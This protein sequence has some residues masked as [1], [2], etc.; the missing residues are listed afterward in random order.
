[1]KLYYFRHPD[2]SKNF[3][4]ELN[5]W[6]WDQ[7]IPGILDE[8]ENS[9]FIGIGT[10]LNERLQSEVAN[11][12]RKFVFGSGVGYGSGI[13]HIDDSWTIYCLRGPLSARALGVAPELALTDAG[14]LIRRCF[15]DTTGKLYKFSYMPHA[16]Y[17][18]TAWKTVTEQLGFG[19]ID[20]HLP[21][22]QV[23]SS[24]SQTEILLTEALHGAI[25]ANALRVPWIPL[26]SGPSIL[27]FKWRDWCS[28]VGLEYKPRTIT[29]LWDPPRRAQVLSSLRGWIKKKLAAI[30]LAH[31]AKTERPNLSNEELIERLTGELERRLQQFKD[32]VVT[33]RL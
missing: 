29:T 31:I 32:D 3:G 8:D 7:L 27:S 24:I 28:S 4:D 20:P 9:V 2:G 14:L 6:L 25:A 12:S 18:N 21:V 16:K 22:G 26:R 17:A 5:P 19:F 33:G 11:A 23:L 10:L 13:P 1:M 30:Q 15:V